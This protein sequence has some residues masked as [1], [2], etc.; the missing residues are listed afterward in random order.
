[1][2][3]T[4][5]AL[6][7]K[8]PP[9]HD[10]FIIVEPVYKD[11][12]TGA[13]YVHKDL[14][15]TQLAYFEEQHV[16][17]MSADEQ[18]GDVESWANYLKSYALEGAFATWNSQGLHAVL[19]Y[20]ERG[21]WTASHPFVPTPQWKAWSNFASG[22]GHP[23]GKAVEFLEDHLP[24]I[25][26][27]DA[28]TLL[29]VLRGLRANATATATTE[30]RPD[31]TAS[32]AFTS[33]RRVQGIGSVDLPGEITIAIPVIKGHGDVFKLVLKVRGSVDGNAH[34]ELRFNMPQAEV[35]LEQVYDELVAKAKSL[36]GDSFTVLRA[37]G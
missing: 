13:T 27:P 23:Q 7:Y 10:G 24:D 25:I 17:P 1:M 20:T 29:T 37:A 32:V 12:L 2:S 14:V 11:P 22:Q 35:V 21:Q 19:D 33:D 3:E 36:L 6:G 18:L 16:S 30:M 31:G 4:N 26:E 9:Q 8:Q 15:N 5:P 28:T 34:L